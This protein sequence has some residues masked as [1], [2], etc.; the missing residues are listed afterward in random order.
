MRFDLVL[1]N[2]NILTGDAACP[3]ARA[4]AVQGG[5]IAAISRDG[6]DELAGCVERD[7]A[8][9][10]VVPGFHDAHCHTAWFGLSLSELR[11]DAPEVTSVDVVYDKVAQQA[12]ITPKG[13]WIIGSGHHPRRMGGISPTLQAIDSVAAE[14]PVWLISS[15]GHASVVNS[16]ALHTLNLNQLHRRPELSRDP[17][18]HMTGLLEEEAHALVLTQARPYTVDQI[19]AAVGRAHEQ[20]LSEGITSVQEAGVGA[21][22]VG[23][24]SAEA[25]A[26]QQARERRLLRVRSTLMPAGEALHRLQLSA[27]EPS[28][29]SL[30]LGIRTG[31][32]DDWLRVGPA[33]F[34]TDGSVLGR[35]AALRDGYPEGEHDSARIQ[36]DQRWLRR[37][38]IEAHLAGWQL[39]VHAQGDSAIDF[40]LDCF[41]EALTIEP[42]ADHRHRIEHCSITTNEALGRIAKLG[43]IPSP[44]GRFVGTAGDGI[45]EVLSETQLQNAYRSKSFLDNGIPLPGSSDRPCTDG[46][47][48]RGIHDMVNRRTASG[49]SMNPHE[50]VSVEQALRAYTWGSAYATFQEE[51]LGTL[52][53]GK[54]ADFVLLTEDPTST[55]PERLMDV[56]VLATSIG[57]VFGYDSTGDFGG[58]RGPSY[59]C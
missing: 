8:G 3:R 1:K 12:R 55:P 54:L 40:A 29:S 6:D 34:F 7:A 45:L 28:S 26:Y 41:E 27:Q 50:A 24:S 4:M 15:S 30:D 5:R 39:A 13:Q 58:A 25:R 52:E 56:E 43:V 47:P 42:R 51:R 16:L 57:G 36:Q 53:V 19:T 14:H 37:Q 17:A 21:G 49:M 46:T 48:M 32:G 18:G 33:K 10:T 38:M 59:R 2:A 35:T 22:L 9:A 20:Y 23:R 11:L 44:Q 31:F